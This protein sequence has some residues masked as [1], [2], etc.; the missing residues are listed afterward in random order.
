MF[1]D[2]GLSDYLQPGEKTNTFKGTPG[3]MAP[4]AVSPYLLALNGFRG[5]LPSRVQRSSDYFSFGVSCFCM[6]TGMDSPT[7]RGA[8]MAALTL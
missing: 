5:P 2:F 1:A 7:S 3:Y 4:E 6:R 8:R